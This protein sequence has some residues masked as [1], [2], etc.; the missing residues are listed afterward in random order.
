MFRQG[1]W[2]DR[3]MRVIDKLYGSRLGS[4]E[5]DPNG[6]AREKIPGSHILITGFSSNAYNV[7]D[8]PAIRNVNILRGP[9]LTIIYNGIQKGK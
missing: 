7:R 4:R 8:Y 6:R 1:T 2:P 9:N 5:Y 3:P